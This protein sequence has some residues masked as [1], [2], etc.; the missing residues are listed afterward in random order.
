MFKRP[1]PPCGYRSHLRI[2]SGAGLSRDSEGAQRTGAMKTDANTYFERPQFTFWKWADLGDAV[3]WSDGD[4]IG[5]RQELLGVL[6]RLEPRG[7]PPLGG[8]L[9]LMAATRQSWREPAEKT[10]SLID[11]VRLKFGEKIARTLVA[12]AVHQM[13]RVADMREVLTTAPAREVLAEMVFENAEWRTSR[14]NAARIIQFLDEGLGEEMLAADATRGAAHG[15]AQLARDLDS[16]RRGMQRLD[17]HTLALRIQTGVDRLPEG[18]EPDLSPAERARA[19]LGQLEQDQQYVGLAKLTRNLMAAVT[20]PRPVSDPDDMPLGGFSD[21][22]NR[23]ALDRL[24]ISELA[25]EDTTLSIRVAMNEALYLR[26]ESPP[27][28]PPRQ[29]TLL[30]ETGIR[31]WG[32]PRLFAASVALALSATNDVHAR[33]TAYR[34]NGEQIVPFDIC[35]REGLVEHLSTLKPELHPGA[36]LPALER[37]IGASELASETVLITS[38]DVANDPEFQQALAKDGPEALFLVTVSRDGRL[39]ILERSRRGAKLIREAKLD[40]ADLF[41]EPEDLLPTIVDREQMRDLPAIL[42]VDPFPLLL[43]HEADP[44]RS[45]YVP[46]HGALS[47]TKDRRLMY[48]TSEAE[49]ARQ[50][51]DNIPAGRFWWGDREVS[52]G[53][54]SAIVGDHGSHGFHLLRIDLARLQCEVTPMS[55]VENEPRAVVSQ[56]PS[57]FFINKS[58]DVQVYDRL[59][60]LRVAGKK[61]ARAEWRHQRFFQDKRDQTWL[62]LAYQGKQLILEPVPL[63]RPTQVLTLFERDADDGPL[64]VTV[65][66]ELLETTSGRRRPIAYPFRNISFRG[67]SADGRRL[68]LSDNSLLSGGIAVDTATLEYKHYIGNP[69]WRIE[70]QA[71]NMIRTRSIRRNLISIS[72]GSSGELQLQTRK[73]LL[74]VRYS[75]NENAIILAQTAHRS[76]SD[77]RTF[78]RVNPPAGVGYKLSVATWADGSKAFLD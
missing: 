7:L 45:W 41:A 38:E 47:L 75:E 9:L 16:L 51:A 59:S 49:G 30:L 8:V 25:N 36:A 74:S 76:A 3:V 78:K 43:S 52:G 35:S 56:G 73:Q 77:R 4:T 71:R 42:S 14:P 66:G 5:F 32:L 29:R 60:G 57:V 26:R 31:T 15:G 46:Y 64:G 65:A 67:V 40:V 33:I 62:A 70:Q 1:V 39:R 6:R 11:I 12:S 61:F 72:L 55:H 34:A 17:R 27:K 37:A 21:I 50:L 24:L 53:A 69:N 63:D 13:D 54:V 28:T 18:A 22:S 23:G 2:D 48:W 20:L 44:R 68:A 10:G 58:S 19:L